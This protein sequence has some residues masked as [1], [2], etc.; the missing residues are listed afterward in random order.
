[1]LVQLQLGQLQSLHDKQVDWCKSK[2]TRTCKS[3]NQ[4]SECQ[5]AKDRLEINEQ[6]VSFR[7]EIMTSCFNGGDARHRREL[8]DTQEVR[9]AC[10][11]KVK[12]L[13][14]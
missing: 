13:C 14:P 1:M 6:C 4:K 12:D 2:G 5:V 10:M 3:L 11:Q 7:R 8:Q 9:E